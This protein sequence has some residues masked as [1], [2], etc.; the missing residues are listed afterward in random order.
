M[1]F[2]FQAELNK[3]VTQDGTVE[4]GLPTD[5]KNSPEKHH[6]L[7]L[8]VSTLSIHTCVY[9]VILHTYLYMSGFLPPCCHI[10]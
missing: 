1:T 7:L 3:P 8:E 2:F 9:V 5:G 6:S 4:S 10:V